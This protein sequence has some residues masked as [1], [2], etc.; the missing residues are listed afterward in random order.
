MIINYLDY[1]EIVRLPDSV[2]AFYKENKKLPS[3]K[4]LD[5]DSYYLATKFLH[6][7]LDNKEL[8]K[9]IAF[10]EFFRQETERSLK[11]VGIEFEGGVKFDEI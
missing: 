6:P 5:D 2:K 4:A 11:E 1:L 8:V 7:D 10:K 3:Q 9:K